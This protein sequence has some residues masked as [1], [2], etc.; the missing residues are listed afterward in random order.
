MVRTLLSLA[1]LLHFVAATS[2]A[3]DLYG[4]SEG[5]PDIQSAGPMTFGPSGILFIG[6]PKG[7]A[8]FAIQTGDSH[9]DPTG[10]EHDL[11]GVKDAIAS[12][13]GASADAV[14]VNDLAVNP[15]TGN[16][17]LLATVEGKGPVL[18]SVSNSKVKVV[19]LDKVHF[20]K[21]ELTDAPE[22]AVVGDGRRQRNLRDDSITDIAFVDGEIIVSGL[23]KSD[24]PSGVRTMVFPFNKADK[25]ASLEIYH[26][27]H[28]RSE[29]TSAI[30][31]FVPFVIDGEPNL[32]AGFVCTPLVKFPIS[33]VD[34]SDR[35]QGTTVAELGNRNRPLDMI[36]YTKDGEQ[37]LLLTNSARGVM[38]ISTNDIERSEGLT[39]RVEGGGTA[40]QTYETVS[41]WQNVVEL[42]K[43]NSTHAVVLID[44][45][46]Q[47]NLKTVELP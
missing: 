22:D 47:L 24:S 3:A 17:F 12:A 11:D 38:K 43:L 4:L 30:R 18:I 31:T 41:S 5:T 10:V 40:G 6:D 42:D 19:S 35:I 2:S 25:G 45:G 7:A 44:D 13:V 28:G 46:G 14:T 26:A 1:V 21:K 33:A 23:R 34:S 20:A 8:V 29:D 32:L 37:Y 15:E 9:G 39:E 16:A 27:A 36:V